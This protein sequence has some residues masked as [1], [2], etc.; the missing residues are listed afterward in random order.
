MDALD[1]LFGQ[2]V[3]VAAQ[4][5]M[6]A[7]IVGGRRWV[8]STAEE[9]GYFDDGRL[10]KLHPKGVPSRQLLEIELDQTLRIYKHRELGLTE[11][12]KGR[13]VTVRWVLG[14]I[15]ANAVLARQVSQD[16][17]RT[18]TINESVAPPTPFAPEELQALQAERHSVSCFCRGL[19]ET[20]L[21]CYG[22]GAYVVDGLGNPV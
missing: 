22:T 13:S 5:D 14:F 6:D 11:Q 9:A 7:T 2:I 15:A 3:A 1:T 16:R 21:R 8:P 19:F 17:E 18:P 4:H 12:F 10:L 20:C